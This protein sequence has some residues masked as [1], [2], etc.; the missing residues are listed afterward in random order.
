MIIP[1]LD[2]PKNAFRPMKPEVKA[3]DLIE[4][5]MSSKQQKKLKKQKSESGTNLSQSEFILDKPG[6]EA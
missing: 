3:E 5:A 6:S 1:D 4:K 2:D